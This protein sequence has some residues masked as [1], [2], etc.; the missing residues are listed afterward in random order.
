AVRLVE[1]RIASEGAVWTGEGLHAPLADR[2]SALREEG[3]LGLAAILVVPGP[4][5]GAALV[6][7]HAVPVPALRA[8]VALVNLSDR[9]PA[10]IEE[11]HA[12]RDAFVIVR[13][14]QAALLGPLDV[15]AL[16]EAAD[17]VPELIVVEVRV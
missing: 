3:I 17:A 6:V 8:V 7:E 11:T 15:P 4:K 5:D 12:R 14:R 9:D 2:C 1:E 16:V 10:A 13:E